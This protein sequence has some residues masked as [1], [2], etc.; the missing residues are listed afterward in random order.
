MTE[1]LF[2]NR[3]KIVATLGPASSDEATLT[4]LVNAGA[5]VLRL[6]CAHADHKALAARVELVR[7]VS[8]KLGV[9]LGILADLQGPKMR[10]GPLKGAEPIYLHP[11]KPLIITT[12]GGVI[13]EA[14]DG[15]TPRVGT[16]YKRLAKDVKPGERVLLD[17]GNIELRVEKVR[18]DEVHTS[19]VYGALLMQ[20]KG[21]NLP[22]SKVSAPTLS[23][24]DLQDLKQVMKLGVD[25]VALSF[26]R[27]GDDVRELTQLIKK[28]NSDARV[29]SKIERPEAVANFDDILAE[30]Y[31]IMVARG[32]MG[33]ELGPE[34]VPALQKQIIAKSL[35]ASKPVITATQ[36]LESMISNPRPTRAE[37]SDVANAIY[38]GTSAIMLSAETASGKYPVRA[39]EIMNT[40]ARVTEEDI[41]NNWHYHHRLPNGQD[42]SHK[43]EPAAVSAATVRAAAYAASESAAKLIVVFTESGA[44]ARHISGERVS[45]RVVAFTPHD[46]TMQRLALSWGITAKKVSKTDS[47][48]AMVEE[49]MQILQD[50]GFIAAGERVVV[51]SGTTRQS[52]LTNIMNVREVPKRTSKGSTRVARTTEPP[53]SQRRNRRSA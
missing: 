53:K 30:S 18:G 36:M 9:P 34:A 8:K 33:V 10:I 41:F 37:A 49:G 4:A 12:A 44:T 27:T 40:I 19:V 43:R 6:N 51:V 5:N 7:S 48:Q 35:A 39:V 26:V 2:K 25:F 46:R 22:G 32:D 1:A 16:S 3:T 50:E 20:F 17:D 29:I 13:G 42:P 28:A 38:D 52:G 31:G 23:H 24:K 11:G 21:L 14:R 45:T 47:S 15:K